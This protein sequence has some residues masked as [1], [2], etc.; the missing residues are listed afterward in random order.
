M[1]VRTFSLLLSTTGEGDRCGSMLSVFPKERGS[2]SVKIF[3]AS[4][5]IANETH[6]YK[7]RSLNF[8]P[9]VET[10]D[11]EILYP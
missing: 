3:S 7:L 10:F 11:T 5:L 8:R 2:F 6:F 4:I 9:L 1:D